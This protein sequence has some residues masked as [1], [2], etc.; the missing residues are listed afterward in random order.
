MFERALVRCFYCE[1]K[2]HTCRPLLRVLRWSAVTKLIWYFL[3][4]QLLA[5]GFHSGRISIRDGNTEDLRERYRIDRP[6]NGPIWSIK[7]KRTD[8]KSQKE[9]ELQKQ[10]SQT[11]PEPID[12]DNT[13]FAFVDWG[14]RLCYCNLKGIPSFPEV[15]LPHDTT[16]LEWHDQDTLLVGDMESF[17]IYFRFLGCFSGFRFVSKTFRN[18]HK[19]W[20]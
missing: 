4:R 7:F 3:L 16:F 17:F 8:T 10:A 13:N 20:K 11:T 1:I 18:S 19:F 15:H 6:S 9:K 5:M 2:N 12:M 14:R